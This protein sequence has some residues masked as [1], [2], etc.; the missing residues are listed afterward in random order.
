MNKKKIIAIVTILA[1]IIAGAGVFKFNGTSGKNEKTR[2]A[3]IAKGDIT[4]AVSATGA[5]EPDSQVE[6]KSKA[7]GEVTEFPYEPG[8]AIKAGQKL[9]TLDPAT[10]RRNVGMKE[11]DLARAI[12]D[13]D[14]AGASLM[15]LSAKAT[16]AVALSKQGLIS[17]QELESAQTAEAQAK[18][19]AEFAEAAVKKARLELDDAK[20]RL[21]ETVIVSPMDGVLLEKTVEKGQVVASGISTFTG[22]TKL[23]LVGDISRIF[24]VALVDET[25]IGKVYAAQKANI[26]ADAYPEMVFDG[27]VT[28]VYPK[29]ESSGAIT[30]FKVKIEITGEGVQK[31]KP[32]M[33]ANVD[34]ILQSKSGV[35]IAPEEALKTDDGGKTHYVYLV[36]GGKPEKRAVKVGLSNGFEAEV[37]QGLREGETVFLR[38]PAED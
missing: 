26:T 12:A 23:G 21:R 1:V 36:G 13:F 18:S 24:I 17:N 16:R 29:G 19:K 4:L 25:D 2:T 7:S 11:S 31:L 20:E 34:L 8:D 3:R 5:I 35:I 33:T 28:R 15:E 38:A 32:G 37:T 10:E 22:G 27:I 14:S 9:L 6:I 30:V